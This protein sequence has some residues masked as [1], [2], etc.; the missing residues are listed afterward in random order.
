MTFKMENRRENRKQRE[1]RERATLLQNKRVSLK[2]I[3]ANKGTNALRMY[4]RKLGVGTRKQEN[5]RAFLTNDQLIEKI[6]NRAIQQNRSL[7][8]NWIA[9]ADEGKP[10]KRHPTAWLDPNHEYTRDELKK[11]A[12]KHGIPVHSRTMEQLLSA[13]K[14]RNPDEE[15]EEI[16]D[17]EYYERLYSPDDAE[18]DERSHRV[19]ISAHN[20]PWD[21]KVVAN[22]INWIISQHRN[23]LT[24]ANRVL[25][26][27]LRGILETYGYNE[28]TGEQQSYRNT[29]HAETVGFPL[30]PNCVEVTPDMIMDWFITN[31]EHFQ[32]MLH[33]SEQFCDITKFISLT[34]VIKSVEFAGAGYVVL[35][36]PENHPHIYSPRDDCLFKVFDKAGLQ[37]KVSIHQIKEELE[38]ISPYVPISK[39]EEILKYYE[40]PAR[41]ILHPEREDG[42]FPIKEK[43]CKIIGQVETV[44]LAPIDVHLGMI[45]QHYFLI[46]DLTDLNSLTS[47]CFAKYKTKYEELILDTSKPIKTKL[48]EQVGG[49]KLYENEEIDIS[50]ID[51]RDIRQ[52]IRSYQTQDAQAGRDV[53][54]LSVKEVREIL[55]NSRPLC[56][57]CQK[58][59]TCY[60]WSLDRIDDYI[61]HSKENLK[62]CCVR[63][64]VK[65]KD[66]EHQIY[67]SD[68]E[69]LTDGDYKVLHREGEQKQYAVSFTKYDYDVLERNERPET[70]VHYGLDTMKIFEDFVLDLNEKTRLE[71][72]RRTEIYMKKYLTS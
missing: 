8:S 15:N 42:T 55:E 2:A 59:I 52:K 37:R 38:L 19:E 32:D 14:M 33:K 45:P 60:N 16:K 36:E 27:T 30:P 3:L 22:V 40:R 72:E 9:R 31:Y 17:N 66:K 28:N 43:E 46:E 25:Y 53:C 41:V 29:S 48:L 57:Y 4:A 24:E 10:I 68:F 61:G 44:E 70:T 5:K 63:C 23:T 35:K 47:E 18:V 54:P 26:I 7:Y 1:K 13:L 11:I 39:I 6:I 34:I 50:N 51:D 67:V 21:K 71:V 62:L 56:E 65:K 69:A 49:R 20:V 58:K 12:K 64:N